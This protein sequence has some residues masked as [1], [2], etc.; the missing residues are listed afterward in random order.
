MTTEELLKPRYK[1]SEEGYPDMI[2]QP[3]QIIE[4]NKW[5]KQAGQ[6]YWLSPKNNHW[7]EPF[8]DRFPSAF[9]KIH[10]WMDRKP[11]EMPEYIQYVRDGKKMAAYK[12]HGWNIEKGY[13]ICE[14]GED[15]PLWLQKHTIPITDTEY[16]V[17][18]A[19]LKQQ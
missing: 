12:I 9:L 15:Y 6:W 1:V 14:R 19:T 2:F 16:E 18:Q 5:D 7:Y 3:N 8:F 17:Y 11:G 4:L 10:W 13:A